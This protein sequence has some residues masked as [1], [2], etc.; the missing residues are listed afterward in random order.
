MSNTEKSALI[1]QE[2]ITKAENDLKNASYTLRLGKKCPTDTVCFH[3]QQCIEKYLKALLIVLDKPFPRTHDIEALISL[4]P[5]SIHIPLTVEEQRRLT[6]YATVTRYPG[7]YELIPLSEA[8]SSVR[9][10]RKI[11]KKIQKILENRG[12]F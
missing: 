8:K 4:L 9:L 1:A 2:W 10:A 11:Q 3:S 6:G 12:L 5:K 7:S